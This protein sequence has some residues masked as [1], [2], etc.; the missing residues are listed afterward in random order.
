M[1]NRSKT[2]AKRVSSFVSLLTRTLRTFWI[3]YFDCNISLGGISDFKIPRFTDVQIHTFP[4]AGGDC[5][6]RIL[7]SLPT[8]QGISALQGAL[9]ATLARAFA[10]VF[11]CCSEGT[12]RI[13]FTD[14]YVVVSHHSWQEIEA[15]HADKFLCNAVDVIRQLTLILIIY[16]MSSLI[17]FSSNCHALLMQRSEFSSSF[18]KF[19]N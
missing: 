16:A 17:K 14:E 18:N 10:W 8:H 19:V 9:A 4:D 7:R 6:G 1:K 15:L 2:V 12:F 13:P 3:G 11:R 5:D